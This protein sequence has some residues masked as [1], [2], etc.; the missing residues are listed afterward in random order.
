MKNRICYLDMDG[1]LV[2]FVNGALREHGYHLPEGT[3]K[4]DFNHQLKIPDPEFWGP[5]GRSFWSNLGWM[6][7]GRELLTELEIMFGQDH[8]VILSSPCGTPGCAEGKLD[9]IKQHLPKYKRQYL[10]GPAKH[11]CAS[12]SHILI[13][14]YDHNVDKFRTYGGFAALVP[15]SW[16]TAEQFTYQ[17]RFDV[18]TFM[19]TVRREAAK[20][21]TG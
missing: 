16:N 6:P 14:D 13:D 1:V 3:V 15:R 21:S 9:W 20:C 10:L 11:L 17:N 5:F 12:P 18:P 8:I 4:W 2:D 7:E 19:E